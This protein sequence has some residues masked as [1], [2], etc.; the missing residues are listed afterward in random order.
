MAISPK[1]HIR[2]P[3]VSQGARRGVR[4]LPV[5]WT[6]EPADQAGRAGRAQAWRGPR[7]A[8]GAGDLAGHGVSHP[9]TQKPEVAME[10]HWHGRPSARGRPPGDVTGLAPHLQADAQPGPLGGVPS[11]RSHGAVTHPGGGLPAQPPL[12]AKGTAGVSEHLPGG[13]HTGTRVK[14]TQD[15]GRGHPGG[16]WGLRRPQGP[17]TRP[18]VA[19]ARGAAGTGGCR[20][21]RTPAP[22]AHV[23]LSFLPGPAWKP[24]PPGSPPRPPAR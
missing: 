17:R 9:W 19:Q 3:W 2:H 18:G 23:V 16:G 20:Q 1:S 6:R 21:P 24:P 8:P 10:G 14:A 12:R 5:A 13:W 22:G 15:G 4:E 7:P 11:V